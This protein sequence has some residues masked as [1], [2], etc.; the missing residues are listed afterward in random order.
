[1]DRMT[2]MH[3]YVRLV[4]LGTF[5]AVA[6]ELRIKQSTVSKWLAALE[7][8]LGAQLVERTTRTRRI[9]DAGRLFYQ[10]AKDILAA[11][12]DATAA[13]QERAPEPRGR[14]RISLPVVFG[15]L[16]VV[17][18]IASFLRRYRS[19]EVEI[20]FSDRYVNLVDEAID[21][22]VRVGTPADSSFRARKLGETGRRLVAAP[23]YLAEAGH[24]RTPRDLSEHQCLLYTGLN[25]GATWVFE[26]AG[27]RLR[28]SVSGRISANNSEALLT[29]ARAGLGIALLATWLV[30]PEL[31]DGSLVPLLTDYRPPS[32]PI[33]ALMPPG[34][35]VHPRVRSLLDHLTRALSEDP[36]LQSDEA[37]DA[38]APR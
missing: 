30:G 34:K 7:H 21:V 13:L 14:I 35:R 25:T 28:A 11:Y 2:A 9:T 20:R 22:A 6:D 4:E 23:G 16:F 38:I 32:A 3:A 26:R 1:M 15:R 33:Q 37:L 8:E 18:H 31:A 10:R 5:S 19:V 36:R 24:P 27:R 29:M 12:D 17:P